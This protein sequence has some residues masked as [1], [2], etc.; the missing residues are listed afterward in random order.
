[1]GQGRGLLDPPWSSSLPA[2][3]S[4]DLLAALLCENCPTRVFFLLATNEQEQ[5]IQPR[6]VARPAR[7]GS[8]AGMRGAE[9]V[10][11]ENVMTALY[12][13]QGHMQQTTVISQ[14]RSRRNRGRRCH[15]A[16]EAL[17]QTRERQERARHLHEQKCDDASA[18]E[19]MFNDTMKDTLEKARR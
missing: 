10:S 5:L 4:V 3:A 14:R 18:S 11:D 7:G 2:L 15:E 1:M 12:A 13:V 6:P 9:Q 19:T 17:T 8:E 16:V